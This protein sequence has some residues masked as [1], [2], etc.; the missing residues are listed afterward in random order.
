MIRA[1][2][3]L[4]RHD[5]PID[6]ASSLAV[7]LIFGCTRRRQTPTAPAPQ[8]GGYAQRYARTRK[9]DVQERRARPN[10][11]KLV[12]PGPVLNRPINGKWNGTKWWVS[13]HLLS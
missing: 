3:R 13:R 5:R 4:Y 7:N 6:G 9:R 10:A 2:R 8:R 12:V 11:F 1:T